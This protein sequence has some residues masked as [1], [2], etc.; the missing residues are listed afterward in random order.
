MTKKLSFF[1]KIKQLRVDWKA[2]SHGYP[3]NEYELGRYQEL[4]GRLQNQLSFASGNHY[5]AAN[6]GRLQEDWTTTANTPTQNFRPFWRQIIA[7]AIKSVDNNPHTV[8]LLNALSTNVVGT[9]LRPQPRVK[10]KSGK[11]VVGINKILA[12]GWKRYN[13]QWDATRR[14]THLEAQ[15]IRFAEIFKTGSTLTNKVAAPAG[16]FLSNQYLVANILRM[17]DTKDWQGTSFND[18]NIK[19]TVFGINLNTNGVPVSYWLN[20]FDKP[21]GKDNIWHSYKQTQAE[22][23]IGVPWIVIALKYLWANENLISDKLT[24]SRIQSM[25]GLF[26][27]NGIMNRLFEGNKNSQDQIEWAPGKILYGD[28][29]DEPKVI[30]ADDSIKEVLAP[31]QSLLLHAISM[32]LGVSYQTTTRD[33]VKVNMASGRINTNEDRKTY[34]VI[35]KWFAKGVCQKDWDQYVRL[36]FAEGKIEGRTIVDYL[37]DPWKYSQ[38]QWQGPGFDFIDPAKEANA[39]IDLI[40]AKMGTYE[41]WFAEKYGTDWRDEFAQMAEEEKAMKE[42]GITVADVT[43]RMGMNKGAPVEEEE[44][45][46]DDNIN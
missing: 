15:K 22:Q 18:P 30:Q 21:I 9:G 31:L 8:A 17:D 24:S 3:G 5:D 2:M 14:N 41:R 26:V 28:K 16:G 11:L 13:D 35:Q 23:Y 37:K 34:K 43:Q 25:I 19:N 38:A 27:P 44:E 42:L 20:G 4:Y 46:E 33:L 10:D 29:G 36:M 7:R 12:E 32:T 45:E 40:D 6:T 1:K 39:A